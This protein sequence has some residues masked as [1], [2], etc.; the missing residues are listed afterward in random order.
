MTNPIIRFVKNWT[1]PIAMIAGALLYFAA[2]RVPVLT[3]N[4][5]L[6]LGAI[7]IIQPVLIFAMLF[8]TFCKVDPHTLHI[9]SWQGW[10]L[11]VQILGFS[12]LS[13]LLILFPH[14]RGRVIVEGAML[15]LVCPTATAGAVITHKLGGDASGLTAYT[16]LV[17]LAVAIIVPVF[18]P[19]VNPH[20]DL[21]FSLS[22]FM[23]MGKVFP[24]LIC[25]F[26]AAMLVRQFFPRLQAKISSYRDLAF[27]IWAVSLA[28]AIAVT[29][30]SIVHAN[31]GLGELVGIAVASLVCCIA[32]FA[33]GRRIGSLYNCPIA[34]GQSLGQKNTVFAIWMGYT[35]LTPV[36][37]IAGGFYSLW[38]N[39]FNSW[40]LYQQRN[41]QVPD[42]P[43]A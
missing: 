42:K 43:K 2:A 34:A 31:I 16:I 24:M 13:S 6:L 18:V 37:A 17:N 25:P 14:M 19:L 41:R 30:R 3:S 4:R 12:L 8:I 23:I 29:T 32:Q 39:A 5:D 40:Q 11:L 33:L 10:L 15:C 38:H 7:S 28:L 21:D 1:L 36:S 35:F 22:F 9:R 20:P 27:N 26:F